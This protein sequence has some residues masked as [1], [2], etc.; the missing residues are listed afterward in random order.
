MELSE[1]GDRVYAAECILNK[2]IR[3]GKLEYLVKWKGWGPKH[4]TWEPK[5]NILDDRL[6]QEFRDREQKL[7]LQSPLKKSKNRGVL[8]PSKVSNKRI[9]YKY[10]KKL[11]SVIKSEN[12]SED[13][14]VDLK[15]EEKE[16]LV[17]WQPTD[18]KQRSFENMI[19]TDIT[20]N[21]TTIT[22][23]EAPFEEGFFNH[24]PF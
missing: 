12:K 6:V 13:L 21:S 22:I 2:R 3:K 4:N 16:S 5:L 9:Q 19:V 15:E 11:L 20:L 24:Q 23:K 10:N 8:S 7:R 18:E 1:M 17:S 14:K